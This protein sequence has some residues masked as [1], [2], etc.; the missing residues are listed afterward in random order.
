MD[1][2]IESEEAIKKFYYSYNNTELLTPLDLEA[3][4]KNN[5]KLDNINI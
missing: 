4:R 3:A 1:L 2:E 5:K